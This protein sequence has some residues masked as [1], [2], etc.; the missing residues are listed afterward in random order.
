MSRAGGAS[1]HFHRFSFGFREGRRLR[2]ILRDVDRVLEGGRFYLMSGPSGVGK[3]TLV[4]LLAGEV[5]AASSRWVQRGSLQLAVAEDRPPRVA[6]VFQRDGL[7]D[8]LSVVENVRLAARGDAARAA[9]L[10][11]L[12][13]LE[14][15]PDEV[16]KLSGGQRKRVGLARALALEPDL[17]LLDE[18]TAGLDPPAT[19]QVL[20]VLRRMHDEAEGRLTM[21]LC[22]HEVRAARE[23]CEAE[24]RLPGGGKLVDIERAAVPLDEPLPVE[25]VGRRWMLGM[26]LLA[27]YRVLHSLAETAL[28]LLPE[29][30][31]RCAVTGIRQLLL[32]LP[33][34]FLAGMFIG[35][36]TLHF[37]VGN[38]PLHGALATEL[39]MGTG[40]VLIAVLV[41]LLIAILYAA[42]AVAGTLA[43]IGSMARDRQ[44]AAY[45]ALGR[46]VRREILSPL[47]W[48]HLIALPLAIGGSLVAA[49]LGAF[50]AENWARA[51]SFESFIPRFLTTV[52][53]SDLAWG[54]LKALGSAFF[55]TW[56]PWHL[57]RGAGLSPSALSEASFRAWFW[58][59]L[60]ILVWNGLLLFPQ[61]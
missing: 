56:I 48:G 60:S 47:L 17:M 39:L 51:T 12:V 59:A 43:R 36:L 46:S 58:T 8:D 53:G 44:L 6:A 32:L 28:A 22:T 49:T 57:A 45:R 55:L 29:Q 35:G 41:P 21:I 18:P 27:A 14:D 19:R 13:G 61:L 24:V 25:T 10:L 1:L 38:D 15:V 23:F 16:S 42:P 11:A 50:L 26:P 4:D 3:S 52:H 9:K 2:W 30:P 40:K 37:V 34:L 54:L 20:D 7:W 33:F 31:L 5:D